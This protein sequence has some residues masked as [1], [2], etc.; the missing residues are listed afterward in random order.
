MD[1][2][3][4]E[5]LR[6]YGLLVVFVVAVMIFGY[7][8]A[9]TIQAASEDPMPATPLLI[10]ALAI[11]LATVGPLV[12]TFRPSAAHNLL[13]VM[14][15]KARRTDKKVTYRSASRHV[16]LY[17]VALA[18]TPMLYGVALLFLAAEFRLMLL[19]LPAVGI[20]AAVGWV[21]LGRFFKAMSTGFVR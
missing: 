12:V 16:S 9:P 13:A 5:R 18:S 17:V 21:V 2:A 1:V 11:S 7:M 8:S 4:R 19:L 20:L 14:K 6:A 15:E 10:G 3:S